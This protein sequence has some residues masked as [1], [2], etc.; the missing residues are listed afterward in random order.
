[1][2]IPCH[3]RTSLK[4]LYFLRSIRLSRILRHRLLYS[5]SDGIWRMIAIEVLD[6]GSN[7][8]PHMAIPSQWI[9]SSAGNVR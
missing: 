1:M 9:S 7:E 8:L 4:I 2:A 3:L 5:L 6:S